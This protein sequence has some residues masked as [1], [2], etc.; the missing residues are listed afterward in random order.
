MNCANHADASAVAYCRTCGKAL[1]ANCTRPVRGV[2]YC[3]DCLGSKMEGVPAG[4]S[5]GAAGFVPGGAPAGMPGSGPNPALAGILAI[6][7]G[8][9]AVYNG[10]YAKGLA[11]L[12]VFV[13]LVIGANAAD[14]EHSTA[15]GV[16]CGLGIAFFVIYQIFDAVRSAKAIQLAQPAPD[17]FGLAATFGGGAKIETSKIPIGAIVLILVGVLFLLHTMGLTEFGLDRY[18]P[19][20]LIFLG[21]WLFARNWGVVGRCSVGCQC[22]RCRTRRIMGPAMLMTIGFLFLLDHTLG[23]AG[24]SRTWPVILLVVGAIKLL[25]GSASTEG[26]I[27]LATVINNLAGRSIPPTPPGPPGVGSPGNVSPGFVPPS[28]V[29]PGSVP[30]ND[31]PPTGEVNRG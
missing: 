22:A 17:P 10:Q 31:V 2:I 28:V 9:G 12:V 20:I 21:G 4:T 30:P 1:C 11:H 13:L 29:P 15:L 25:Q 27:P 6:F 16:F 24:F 18:W 26:H 14:S 23:V 8:V 19:L 3:E 7:P 5:A